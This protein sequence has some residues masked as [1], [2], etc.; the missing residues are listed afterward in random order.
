MTIIDTPDGIHYAR[1]CALRGRLNLETKGIRFKGR[2]SSTI[3][4]ELAGKPRMTR[5][6]ALAWL[7][8]EIS[9]RLAARQNGA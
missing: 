5:K 1:L 4:A 3:V 9:A 2:A 8:A 6:A 7:D